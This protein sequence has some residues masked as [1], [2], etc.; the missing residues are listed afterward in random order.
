M[1]NTLTLI[2]SGYKSGKVYSQV[3]NTADGDFSFSGNTNATRVNSSGQVES[4]TAGTPR[5]DYSNGSC[6]TLLLEGAATN[7]VTNSEI[8]GG[9]IQNTNSTPASETKSGVVGTQTTGW[10]GVTSNNINYYTSKFL[11]SADTGSSS[12][13]LGSSF[14][15]DTSE[16]TSDSEYVR[17]SISRG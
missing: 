5:L 1:A 3:P 11:I 10:D 7:Y 12:F 17:F 9:T 15:I 13:I 6:P 14:F 2:P 16:F 4:V 8:A